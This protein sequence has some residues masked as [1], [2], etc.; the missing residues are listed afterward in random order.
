MHGGLAMR[1]EKLGN[2]IVGIATPREMRNILLAVARGEVVPMLLL[3]K[4][5]M[6]EEVYSRRLAELEELADQEH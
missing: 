4:T 2:E 3:T 5:W 6:E 1:L